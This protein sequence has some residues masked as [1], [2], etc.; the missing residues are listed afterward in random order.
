MM[1]ASVGTRAAASVCLSTASKDF[2]DVDLRRKKTPATPT[3]D[4]HREDLFRDEIQ[5]RAAGGVKSGVDSAWMEQPV[6]RG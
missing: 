4:L 5:H 2:P 6:T 1:N 3:E